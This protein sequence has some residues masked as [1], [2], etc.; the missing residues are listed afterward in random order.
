MIRPNIAEEHPATPR[1][2]PGALVYAALFIA[3][4]AFLLVATARAAGDDDTCLACHSDKTMTT[5]HGKQTVSIYVDGK[6]FAASVHAALSCT[7]CH[8]DLEGK[9]IPHPAPAKVNCGT[10]HADEKAKHDKSLHGKALARGD[11]LAPRCMSCHGNHDIV[12]VKD[13][14][15]PVAPLKI[16]FTCGK[17]HQEGT[18]VSKTRNIPEHDIL[19]NYSE[20]IHGQGLLKRG[21]TVAPNLSLIHI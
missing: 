7:G 6:R 14:R 3:S 20:S 13:A 9:D 12:P 1:L 21:L 16:P 11:P 2:R 5:Q 8:A 18:P 10:C 15:S 17:C 4:L 19:E